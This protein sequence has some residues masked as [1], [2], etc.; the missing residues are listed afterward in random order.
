L[1]TGVKRETSPGGLS[2]NAPVF[3]GNL[4]FVLTPV[5]V[6]ATWR[7]RVECAAHLPGCTGGDLT[8][9]DLVARSWPRIASH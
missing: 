9:S 7:M 2:Q 6:F 4:S 5:T 8:E 1:L 3:R